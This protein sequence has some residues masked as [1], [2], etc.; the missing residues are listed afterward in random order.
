[1]ER[2]RVVRRLAVFALLGAL[3]FAGGYA[4]AEALPAD[5]DAPVEHDMDD[6]GDMDHGSTP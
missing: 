6:M 5:D 1:M 2:A 3:G 4:L